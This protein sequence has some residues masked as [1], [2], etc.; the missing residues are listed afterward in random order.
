MLVNVKEMKMFEENIEAAFK[1][2]GEYKLS[3]DYAI[4]LIKKG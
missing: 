4:K 3:G 2:K 1:K